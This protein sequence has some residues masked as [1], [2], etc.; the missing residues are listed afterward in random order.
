MDLYRYFH[1]H[2]NPRLRG[3]LPRYQELFEL[4]Q[5]ASEL[6][7]ALQRAGIRYS[8]SG[9]T[10]GESE[11]VAGALETLRGVVSTLHT[12]IDVHPGDSVGTMRQMV[13]ERS[14]APGWEA[15][16]VLVRQRM[17]L[18]AKDLPTEEDEEK[19]A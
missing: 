5:A 9:S 18:L 14:D 2:F 11:L 1:P 19:V 15:W 17:D 13:D 6:Q 10:W 12:L 8:A 7:K 16:C 3:V 4:H